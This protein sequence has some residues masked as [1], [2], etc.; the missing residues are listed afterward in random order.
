MYSNFVSSVVYSCFASWTFW[1]IVDFLVY[2]EMVIMA[3]TL[4]L[5]IPEFWRMRNMLI[6]EYVI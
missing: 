5:Y 1:K 3:V 4:I 6:Q 2:S